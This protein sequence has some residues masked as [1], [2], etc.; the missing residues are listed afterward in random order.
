MKFHKKHSWLFYQWKMISKSQAL[1]VHVPFCDSICGYCDFCRVK[2]QKKLVDQWLDEFQNEI[3]AGISQTSFETIYIGGG[4]PS[5]LS[6]NQLERLLILIHPYSK[7]CVEFTIE[8]NPENVNEKKIALFK[9]YGINRVSIG[10]QTV[11]QNLLNEM[12]RHHDKNQVWNVI[13]QLKEG[14]ISNI[15]VDCMYSLPGQTMGMLE[16]TLNEIVL[17]DI[18]HVSIYSLTIEEGSQ[19]YR[20]GKKCLDEDLEAEMYQK[21]ID[22]LKEHGFYRYEISNFCKPGF[23]SK[24]NKHYWKYHDFVGLSLGASGKENGIR[25]TNTK[26][27]QNYFNKNYKEEKIQ[28]SLDD[29]QFEALMMGLRMKEG[30][31][32][33]DFQLRFGCDL[34]EKFNSAIEKGVNLG[35]IERDVDFLRCTD[36]GMNLCNSVIELFM[37]DIDS[38]A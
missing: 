36:I 12:N 22:F 1:Y 14:G 21:I 2:N 8:I 18:S 24:H 29:Q 19:F 16:E 28:L 13:Q 26:N 20:D 11:N 10:V 6:E 31:D 15:S 30:I 35:W 3:Q 17:W 25:Y 34:K 37:D 32:I 23:E 4:T 5:C 9:Q 7:A 38:L 27:F 33:K